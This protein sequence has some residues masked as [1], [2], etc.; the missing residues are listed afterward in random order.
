M[1]IVVDLGRGMTLGKQHIF[2]L[3]KIATIVAI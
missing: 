1:C 3:R 2:I